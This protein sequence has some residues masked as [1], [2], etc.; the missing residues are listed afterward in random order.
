MDVKNENV[1]R[2]TFSFSAIAKKESE[3]SYLLVIAFIL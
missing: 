2:E 1:P 3:F